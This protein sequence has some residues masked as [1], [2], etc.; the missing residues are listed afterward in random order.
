MKEDIPESWHYKDSHRV[1]PITV[2]ADLG[3]YIETVS[4][5]LVTI[6]HYVCSSD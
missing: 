1:A 5:S 3:W 2:V 4:S 6:T